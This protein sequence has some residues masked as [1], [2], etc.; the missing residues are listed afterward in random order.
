MRRL[1]ASL[2]VITSAALG[3]NPYFG[4][5]AFTTAGGDL[6]PSN[7][8]W[9]NAV[10]GVRFPRTRTFAVNTELTG[11]YVQQT[12]AFYNSNLWDASLRFGAEFRF[13][14]PDAYIMPGMMVAYASDRLPV[15]DTTAHKMSSRMF[16]GA[17]LGLF[18]NLGVVL[19]RIGD[20]DFDV[21]CG[22]DILSIGIDWVDPVDPGFAPWWHP[23]IDLSGLALGLV[24]RKGVSRE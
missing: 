14:A 4:V 5:K 18:A 20:W 24:A 8:T 10:V 13:A 3:V 15:W 17:G 23:S 7:R 9:A 21:Q 2:C 22:A 19:F 12:D 1:L 16:G 11:T 6:I